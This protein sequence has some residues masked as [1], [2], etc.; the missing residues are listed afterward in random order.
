[1]ASEIERQR[2]NFIALMKKLQAP[3]EKRELHLQT[4]P[5]KLPETEEERYTMFLDALSRPDRDLGIDAT[6]IEAHCV[7]QNQKATDGSISMFV[8]VHSIESMEP[9]LAQQ[10]ESFGKENASKK[11]WD[12]VI[13]SRYGGIQE[14]ANNLHKHMIVHPKLERVM[15]IT[16][17]KWNGDVCPDLLSPVEEHLAPKRDT[18]I[19]NQ[20]MS[21]SWPCFCICTLG[22]LTP[23]CLANQDAVRQDKK[24]LARMLH[25]EDLVEAIR[26][27]L[28]EVAA[29]H[30]PEGTQLSIELIKTTYPTEPEHYIVNALS[31]NRS[32]NIGNKGPLKAPNSVDTNKDQ[33]CAIP[34]MQTN[35]LILTITNPELLASSPTEDP[36]TWMFFESSGGAPTSESEMKRPDNA[37]TTMAVAA[38]PADEDE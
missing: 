31:T 6:P 4:L 33:L 20:Y 1:M 5:K 11:I 17:A 36:M 14:S 26:A 28:P 35:A 18:I 34:I 10:T 38:N 23:C 15:N 19:K 21:D 30:F 29:K 12:E 2:R 25:K 24:N 9:I 27:K 16:Q 8:S 7:R 22:L 13:L 3:I 32:C 37:P